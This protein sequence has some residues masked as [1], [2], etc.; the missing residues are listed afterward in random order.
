MLNDG[1]G[2]RIDYLRMSVTDR[3]D[4]RCRYCLGGTATFLPR[5]EILSLEEIER[6]AGAFVRMGVRRIRL[7]GGEPLGRRGLIGLVDRLGR[8]AAAG[9][10]DELTLTTNGT[11]LGP[12]AG[13]LAAAGL[14][15]VNV[16]LD[17]LSPET[18]RRLT[19][20]GRIAPVLEGI[21]AAR[22]AG[23]AVKV[24]AVALRGVIEDEL[25]ALVAW[26]GAQGC[27]LTLIE[28]MPIG[29][30]PACRAGLGVSAAELRERL[31]RHWTL[32]DDPHRSGGP[33]RYLRV[34]ETGRRVGIIAPHRP[35]FCADCS[36]VRVSA[37]GRLIPC[38]GHEDSVDLRPFLRRSEAD[39]ALEGEIRA[40]LAAKPNGHAFA[41]L[42]A[43]RG[44]AVARRMNVTGG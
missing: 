35:G 38:L 7:T 27:D 34:A 6:L 17:T 1:I 24:N 36:R 28:P 44:G 10:L 39:V 31:A 32:A 15:R 33:A 23:L 42:A 13:A 26:C 29:P 19:G 37:A 14:G 3:C 2:R 40:A 8:Q 20:G 30:D 9:Q 4:L 41:A 21:V 11:R 22:A 43:G 18:F 12:L 16:S 5:A 25:D